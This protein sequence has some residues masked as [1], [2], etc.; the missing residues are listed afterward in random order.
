MTGRRLEVARRPSDVRTVA[1]R[2]FACLT[3]WG[4]GGGFSARP[5]ALPPMITPAHVQA[6]SFAKA[7][8]TDITSI[9]FLADQ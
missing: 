7:I 3:I 4:R 6:Q 1:V 8:R 2:A 9:L 5:T